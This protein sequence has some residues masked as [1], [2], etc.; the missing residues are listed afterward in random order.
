MS[1]IN[2]NVVFVYFV[3]VFFCCDC[4][5]RNKDEYINC[6]TCNCDRWTDGWTTE[7]NCYKNGAGHSDLL[8]DYAWL[9]YDDWISLYVNANSTKRC[10]QTYITLFWCH[11]SCLW[12]LYVIRWWMN[13]NIHE[14]CFSYRE[15]NSVVTIYGEQRLIKPFCRSELTVKRRCQSSAAS[16]AG[17]MEPWRAKTRARFCGRETISGSVRERDFFPTERYIFQRNLASEWPKNARHQRFGY[18]EP[19]GV[20]KLP[21]SCTKYI[22]QDVHNVRHKP[23][24][25]VS[26]YDATGN[27]FC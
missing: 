21:I 18:S 19:H 4:F 13:E 1:E 23:R 5:W 9:H 27:R 25:R 12:R 7:G 6:H 20:T 17:W 3:I 2:L 8:P 11:L 14:K 24:W 10:V 16:L 22:K 26:D 15:D